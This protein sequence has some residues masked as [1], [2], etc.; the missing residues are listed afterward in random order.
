MGKT[1]TR[2]SRNLYIQASGN[3]R[4]WVF[5]YSFQGRTR[6]LGLGP[7]RQVTV[8]KAEALAYEL[9]D[10]IA[11]GVD[12][13]LQRGGRQP[14]TP[15]FKDVAG[16]YIERAI[17]G[18]KHPKSRQ[19]WG[20]SLAAYV[21]P[22]IG[23]MPVSLI[24]PADVARCL[25]PIWISHRETS[26]KVRSRIERVMNAAKAAGNFV[27]EN[28]ARL[29]VLRNLLPQR[30]R[31]AV[32]HYAAMA[33]RDIPAFMAELK[34]KEPLS[35][36]ALEWTILTAVRTSDT[37]HASWAEIDETARLWTNPWEKTKSGRPHR[38]P[39]TRQ[40]HELLGRLSRDGSG[41]LFPNKD[42]KALS[43]MTMQ[44]LF[45]SMRPGLTVHGFRSAAKDWCAE[46]G[47]LHEV[48]EAMIGHAVAKNQT[49][50]AYLRTDFL[51][52]RR[53]MMQ[54]WADFILPRPKAAV[55]P[56]ERVIRR[57]GWMSRG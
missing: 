4:T 52:Q 8:A 39:L 45:K 44:K 26:R 30:P 23:R 37:L 53:E 21:Y 48:S 12:P 27:G 29:D 47:I 16:D 24:R 19:Q 40:T 17:L 54:R 5:R 15:S 7:L 25:T 9:R 55:R 32:A 41:L 42:G 36:R 49:V 13:Q 31:K 18:L 10:K 1:L 43:N 38:I 3:S 46:N 57:S 56:Q 14:K 35:A 22:H 33:W 6:D 51:D 11:Q 50:A 28:P 2:I 34:G 20:N